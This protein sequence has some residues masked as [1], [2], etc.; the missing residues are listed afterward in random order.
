M[1]KKKKISNKN[2]KCNRV[3]LKMST[4]PGL[5]TSNNWGW[6]KILKNSFTLVELSPLHKNVSDNTLKRWVTAHSKQEVSDNTLKKG[7]HYSS[8]NE[9][10]YI[11]FK[12]RFG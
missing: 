11:E 9:R 8:R 5:P 3:W 10:I 7:E 4:S 6:V 2:T 1:R 12:Q